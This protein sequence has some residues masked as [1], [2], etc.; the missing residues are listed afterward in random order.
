MKKR[1]TTILAACMILAATSAMAVPISG[2]IDMTGGLQLTTTE[3]GGVTFANAEGI[4]FIGPHR[5][6]FDTDDFASIPLLTTV[7]MNNL[8]F[9]PSLLPSIITSLWSLTNGSN[10]YSFDLTDIT[11]TRTDRTL[12]LFGH[13][14][15]HATG[16]DSTAGTWALTTQ[17][18]TGIATG[19]LSFSD[20]T[21]S[22]A[23]VPEPGTM[24]LLGAG[25]LGLAIFGKRR[26]IKQS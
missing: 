6:I 12:E 4:T 16:F 24:I 14:I 5:V 23:P 9:A 17:S 13:G 19:Q 20:N 11:V 26:M 2:T 21:A 7:S 22:A 10:S 1:L 15:M 3:L 25:M 18:S 8:T